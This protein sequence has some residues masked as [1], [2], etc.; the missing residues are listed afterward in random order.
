MQRRERA[1][2][3]WHTGCPMQVARQTEDDSDMLKISTQLSRDKLLLVL[4]GSLS[5]PWVAEVESVWLLAIVDRQPNSLIIDLSAVTFVTDEGKRLLEQICARGTEI[6]SS[7]LLTR[8]L[9]EEL[10][11]KHRRAEN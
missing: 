2:T 6:V 1:L 3:I 8:E 9:A 11:H 4:E 10:C 7:D 5:G